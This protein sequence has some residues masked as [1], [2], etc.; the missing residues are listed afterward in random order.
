MENLGKRVDVKL[1]SNEKAIVKLSSKPIFVII[2][3]DLVA[4]HNTGRPGK[5]EI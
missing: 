4:I 3:E 1:V 2:N 5:D